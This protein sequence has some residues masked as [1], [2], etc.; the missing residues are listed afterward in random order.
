MARLPYE[1]VALEADRIIVRMA[2]A[3]T[4]QL[5]LKYWRR[6]IDFITACGWT[7]RELDKETLRRIDRNWNVYQKSSLWR[8]C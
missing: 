4:L 3:P 6:Y 8:I 7:D 1:V 2:L 5:S